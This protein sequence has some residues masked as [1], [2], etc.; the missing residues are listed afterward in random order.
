M[1]AVAETRRPPQ[2]GLAVAADPDRRVRLLNGLGP[3]VERLE[4]IELAREGRGTLRPQ[5]L[6]DAD[7]LV[8]YRA[9]PLELR[10]AERLE[11]LAHP[12]HADAERDASLRE[13]VD[14]RERLRRQHRVAV[15]H[16]HHAR[17]QAQP[18]GLGGDERHERQLIEHVA[19]ARKGA[20]DRVRILRLD[21]DGKHQVVGDHDGRETQR[22]AA[23]DERLQRLGRRRLTAGRQIEPVSHGD[24]I[25]YPAHPMDFDFT[26]GE[27]AFAE[28]VRGFLRANPPETF[29][30]DGM[31]AGYGSGANSRA[32]LRA[33][34]AQGWLTMC[35]P[36]AHGGR[37]APMFMKLV[38]MEELALAGAPFGP[39]AGVWQTADAVIEL[40]T[41]RLR[42]EVLPAI[43]RG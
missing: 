13:H 40:G 23:L 43:A 2:G 34:G 36:K 30:I 3:T 7:V 14:R 25:R 4:S 22:L 37:E 15:G 5:R 26:V 35:W 6:E 10:R 1:P 31:D 21:R 9:P 17:D 39:L 16:D 12:S 11:L 42:R 18:R 32:F 41:E 38:L 27:R 24:T 28:E 19:L 8:S 20:A 29:A 33:L